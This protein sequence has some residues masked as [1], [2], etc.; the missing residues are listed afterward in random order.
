MH[1]FNLSWPALAHP[2][3]TLVGH[4]APLLQ[5]VS[6][7]EAYLLR[8]YRTL[9]FVCH[10][11]ECTPSCLYLTHHALTHAQK[12]LKRDV[13]PQCR[14]LAQARVVSAKNTTPGPSDFFWAAVVCLVERGLVCGDIARR[15]KKSKHMIQDWHAHSL[16]FAAM[17]G[18]RVSNVPVAA[19]KCVHGVLQSGKKTIGRRDSSCRC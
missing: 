1:A 11:D 8:V 10:L 2:L 5:P 12:N 14:K 15:Y 17:V 6:Q 19:L 9:C 13:P 3:C 4:C 7:A 16:K 18:L